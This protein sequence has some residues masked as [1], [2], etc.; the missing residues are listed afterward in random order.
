MPRPP[1]GSGAR[2]WRSLHARVSHCRREPVR[3]THARRWRTRPATMHAMH[4][5]FTGM[6]E[7]FPMTGNFDAKQFRQE[8]GSFTTGVTIVTTVD[9]DGRDVG[10]TAHQ[11]GRAQI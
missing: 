9:A 6:A 8:L 4:I 1:S 11:I 3:S 7:P 10:M 2:V 5:R